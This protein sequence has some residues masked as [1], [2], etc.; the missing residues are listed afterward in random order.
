MTPNDIEVL[1]H[2]YVSAAPHPRGEAPA[3]QEAY[4]DLRANGLIEQDVQLSHYHTT[5]RGE[6]HVKLL[7]A[8][9]WPT[10]IWVDHNGKR[11]PRQIGPINPD[12]TLKDETPE[13]LE[14]RAYTLEY[15]DAGTIV[16]SRCR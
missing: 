13:V 9:P 2:C 3:V 16:L 1:I 11:I 10:Q 5:D 6:A 7:C 4:R 8:T 15:V 12:D 14:D